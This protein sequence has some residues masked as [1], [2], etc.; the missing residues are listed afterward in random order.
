MNDKAVC[1]QI[2]LCECR[3]VLAVEPPALAGGKIGMGKSEPADELSVFLNF[4]HQEV[5]RSYPIGTKQ[6]V[7]K[8]DRKLHGQIFAADSKI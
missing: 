3:V 2:H 7:N 4:A 8:N 1:E 6:N 5:S